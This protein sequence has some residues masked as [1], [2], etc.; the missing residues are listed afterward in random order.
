LRYLSYTGFAISATPPLVAS[1]SSRTPDDLG[2]AFCQRTHPKCTGD[3]GHWLYHACGMD[4]KAIKRVA[5]VTLRRAICERFPPGPER[6]AW[7]RWLGAP[8]GWR[9]VLARNP[10][11][12]WP[13]PRH[14]VTKVTDLPA[15]RASASGS[16]CRDAPHGQVTHT[17]KSPRAPSSRFD[18]RQHAHWRMVLTGASGYMQI[19]RGQCTV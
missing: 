1:L 12:A 7:L 4:E 9:F 13:R 15:I 6:R 18:V 17:R 3:A 11:L 10:A 5:L 2:R 19:E 16:M 14:R 8:F